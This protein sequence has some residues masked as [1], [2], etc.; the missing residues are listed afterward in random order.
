MET[1]INQILIQSISQSSNK[2]IDKSVTLYVDKSHRSSVD[3][4][5]LDQ[6]AMEKLTKL[7]HQVALLVR[8]DIV[9]Q[10]TVQR[11]VDGLRY[12]H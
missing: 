9:A 12:L 10:E 2:S 7:C 6:G 4:H 1:S 8:D 5:S 3:R 11:R